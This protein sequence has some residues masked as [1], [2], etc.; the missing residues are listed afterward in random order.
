[1]KKYLILAT[2][3]LLNYIQAQN[4]II[5]VENNLA[6]LGSFDKYSLNT[7]T[8]SF[9]EQQGYTVYHEKDI[10]KEIANTRCLANYVNLIN[11]SGL[12]TTA[13]QMIIKDCNGNIILESEWGKTREKKYDIAYREAFRHTA[14]SILTKKNLLNEKNN[15]TGTRINN[16]INQESNKNA[17]TSKTSDLIFDF[18]TNGVQGELKDANNKVLYKITQT[19]VPNLY[20]ASNNYVDGII[21]SKDDKWYFEFVKNGEKVIEE[22][23]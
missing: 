12:F 23:K 20:T 5:I 22:I 16:S 19:S 10:P 21:Y 3:G 7:F 15:T 6:E 14:K 17:I 11:E 13:L 8:K 9:F 2:L 1:M 4:K 18:K